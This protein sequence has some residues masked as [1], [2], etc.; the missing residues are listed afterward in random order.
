MV[1]NHWLTLKYLSYHFH[2]G[3]EHGDEIKL[4][5]DFSNLYDIENKT[6]K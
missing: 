3:W 6:G 1:H 5:K 4:S 2:A